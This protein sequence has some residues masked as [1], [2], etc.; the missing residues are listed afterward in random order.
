MESRH[1]IFI[2][3][4]VHDQLGGPSR[5]MLEVREVLDNIKN[6][7]YDLEEATVLFDDEHRERVS[8]L[9]VQMLRKLTGP[10]RLQGVQQALEELGQDGHDISRLQAPEG[11]QHVDDVCR[12]YRSEDEG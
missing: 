9:W 4:E 1:L 3:D 6:R 2:V 12:G 10:I 5:H 8:M 7:F 11:W